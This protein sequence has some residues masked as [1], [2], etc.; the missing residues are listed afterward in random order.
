MISF[1]N[2]AFKGLDAALE[3]IYQHLNAMHTHLAELIDGLPR[4]LEVIDKS[5]A[6]A[7]KVIDRKINLLEQEIDQLAAQTLGKFNLGGEDMR[8]I[9]SALKVA[10]GLE[11]AGDKLKNCAKRLSKR[12]YPLE[13]AVKQEITEAIAALK[14]MFPIAIAMLLDYNPDKTKELLGHGARIQQAYRQVLIHLYHQ[15]SAP[16][17]GD[18]THI[19]LVA[20]NLDQAADMAVEIMKVCHRLHLSK[21][22]EAAKE[23]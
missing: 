4:G 10:G 22:Y 1:G 8:Y 20:K 23:S 19:L 5:N 11:R 6:D 14:A 13:G 12:T 7:A 2:H 17:F 9:L 18:H 21:E 3:G 15:Q 16:S